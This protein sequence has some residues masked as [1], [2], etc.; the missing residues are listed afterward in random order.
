MMQLR[1]VDTN[2]VIALSALLQ[3]RNVTRAAK[4]VGLGQSSMSHALARL[5]AHF[6]DALL[7]PSGR[8]MVLTDRAKG[9]AAPV[10]EAVAKLEK[11]FLANERFLPASS[12]RVFRIAATDNLALYVLPQLLALLEQ[13]A[14]RVALRVVQLG[15]DWHVALR[16]GDLDVKLGRR[17]ELPRGLR[18]EVLFEE[19]MECVIRSAHPLRKK[20]PSIA[21]YAR[22]RHVAI[23]PASGSTDPLGGLVESRLAATGLTR[24]V[25]LSV[26]HFAVA[27]LIVASTDLALTASARLIA[28]FVTPFRLRRIELPFRLPSYELTQVWAERA[29]DDAASLWLRSAIRRAAVAASSP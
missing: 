22:L 28:P 25:V 21:E 19:R 29:E 11:V 23:H 14:P 17:Y 18:D 3:E 20:R 13:E 26:P 15:T 8:T 9:L 24:Q 27:P 4:K 6:G 16:D 5:R 10:A 12:R 2:L 7:V 1:G